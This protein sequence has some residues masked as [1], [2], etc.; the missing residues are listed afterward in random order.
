MKLWQNSALV[1]FV[2]TAA[3]GC[4]SGPVPP[5]GFPALVS[6]VAITVTQEGSPL[7]DASVT[8]VPEDTSLSR[9]PVMGKTDSNGVAVIATYG[10]FAGAPAG[11]F[12]VLITKREYTP[13]KLP[14]PRADENIG[15]YQAAL[16]KEVCPTYDLVNPEFNSPKTTSASIEIS[17][18]STK[19]AIDV[20][21][22]VRVELK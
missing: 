7:A 4:Q 5:E 1:L 17:R 3:T 10:Q 12:K 2:W 13:S 21:K 9:W 20:G 11:K 19:H 22:A 18:A 15:D 6:G 14:P 16:A 8:L